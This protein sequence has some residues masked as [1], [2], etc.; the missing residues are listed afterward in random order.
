GYMLYPYRPTSV[1]NR[2][3]FNF[4]SLSPKAYSEAQQG[5]ESWSMQT[6]CLVLAGQDTTLDVKVRFLHLVMREVCEAEEGAI[7]PVAALCVDGQMFQTWQEA[8]EREV[9]T[10]T[11][12]LSELTTKRQRTDF[13]FPSKQETE[14]LRDSS[15]R[16][17]GVIVRNQQ[18][19]EGSIEIEAERI[20]DGLFKITARILNLTPM[21][22]ATD[23][24]RDEALLSALVS[25]HTILSARGG[26]FISSLD[27]PDEF[28][29]AVAHCNNIGTWPVLVG[30]EGE[31]GVMLS[32]P[33]ILYDYPQ[34][35]PESSGDLFD[36]T[37]IDEI[38]TLRIMTLTDEEKRE[39]RSAD[40][41]ARKILERTETLPAEQLMKMHGAVRGLRPV[42]KEHQ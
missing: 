14:S 36:G 5:T 40:E 12:T 16:L 39:M 8:V 9:L 31:R 24:S 13:S 2:Q 25:T 10:K 19:I 20:I 3:R 4:G 42:D 28:R 37:E 21:E 34:I 23:A 22:S 32:S 7:K 38:L 15:D 35:A 17:V 26:E 11:F 41:R 6:E 33:I 30:D 27:P 1:K 29:D 18:A